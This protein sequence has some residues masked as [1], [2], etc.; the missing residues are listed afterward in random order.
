MKVSDTYFPFFTLTNFVYLALLLLAS[1]CL[2]ST[3][4]QH[5]ISLSLILKS[6]KVVTLSE[7]RWKHIESLLLTLF[8]KHRPLRFH[9]PVKY[10]NFDVYRFKNALKTLSKIVFKYGMARHFLGGVTPLSICMS[11]EF[12]K[13]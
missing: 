4:L 7:L 10:F 9:N 8:Q 3:L 11:C 12:P 13:V 5:R 1:S 2:D 6:L